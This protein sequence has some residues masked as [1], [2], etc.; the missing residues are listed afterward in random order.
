MGLITFWSCKT[1]A[2]IAISSPP[3]KLRIS[4]E[5]PSGISVNK[6]ILHHGDLLHET[7]VMAIIQSGLATVLNNICQCIQSK[8]KPF[9]I[10]PEFVREEHLRERFRETENF[11]SIG[12]IQLAA[13]AA[14]PLEIFLR[15]LTGCY[16]PEPVYRFLRKAAIFQKIQ[17]QCQQIVCAHHIAELKPNSPISIH[18][19]MKALEGPRSRAKLSFEAGPDRAENRGK[20]TL[21]D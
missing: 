12:H 9:P 13:E 1:A 6:P 19:L 18:V 11:N 3:V 8:A 20:V 16:F 17:F 4:V 14:I 2:K 15:C 10:N 5:R 7:F 21:L